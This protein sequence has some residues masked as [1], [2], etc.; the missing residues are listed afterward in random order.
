LHNV[1]FWYIPTLT[2]MSRL[3]ATI[4]GD[5]LITRYVIYYFSTGHNPSIILSCVW[6]LIPTI[7]WLLL[8]VRYWRAVART[9]VRNS[10][11]ALYSFPAYVSFHADARKVSRL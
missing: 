5:K 4:A 2:L 3:Q 7:R 8:P 11:T 9:S 1:F 10:Q 6:G